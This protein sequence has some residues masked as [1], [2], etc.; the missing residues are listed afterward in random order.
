MPRPRITIA[1]ANS[2]RTPN[3]QPL[4]YEKK[5]DKIEQMLWIC[6]HLILEQIFWEALKNFPGM[7][8][9]DKS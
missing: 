2:A 3:P 6:R 9:P 4:T 8:K 5:C 1:P 7:T